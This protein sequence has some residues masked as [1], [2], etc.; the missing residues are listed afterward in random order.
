MSPS[1]GMQRN[2]HCNRLTLPQPRSS[3]AA[4]ARPPPSARRLI[5]RRAD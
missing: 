3:P 4:P 5:P 2:F 1:G